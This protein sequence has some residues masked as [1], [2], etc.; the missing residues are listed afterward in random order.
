M[1]ET[2][3]SRVHGVHKDADFM[4]GWRNRNGRLVF[5]YVVVFGVIM[6]AKFVCET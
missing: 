1:Y 4:V 6:E 2:N 3:T 5:R